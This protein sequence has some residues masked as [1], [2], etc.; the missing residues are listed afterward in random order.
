MREWRRKYAYKKGYEMVLQLDGDGQHNPKYIEKMI[1]AMKEHKADII[2]GSRF[3]E[4]ENPPFSLR[5]LGGRIISWAIK[6]TTGVKIY[7]PT[8]GMRL[9]N[10]SVLR[11]FAY[12]MNY[13]PEPDTI[14][15]L[16]RRGAKVKEVQVEMEERIAGESYLNLKNA[17]KYMVHMC[18][19]ILLVQIFRLRGK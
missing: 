12:I 14:S 2:I 4:S 7:D 18:V 8:S 19:S 1:L 5:T 17:V 16:M 15:F 9:Y 3:V 13:T 11:E 10:K 6:L